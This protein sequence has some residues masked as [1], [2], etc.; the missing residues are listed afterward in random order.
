MSG[1]T[2]KESQPATRAAANIAANREVAN[3]IREVAKWLIL[4]FGAIGG[5]LLTG[6]QLSSIGKEGTDVF[7]AVVGFAVG[8]AGAGIALGFTVVV[9]LPTRIT[10]SGLA[11]NE[12]KGA[13]MRWKVGAL[14]GTLVAQDIGILDGHGE[15]IKDFET[16]RNSAINAVTAA[17][18]ELEAKEEEGAPIKPF[19][20]ALE[21]AE[22]K[23][24]KIGATSGELLSIAL[25]E[26]V[27]RRMIRA[28]AAVFVGGLM[29]AGG[30]GLFSW[31]TNQSEPDPPAAESVPMRPTGVTV[32]LTKRGQESLAAKLGPRCNTAKFRALA[33]GG[34]P[35][36]LEMVALRNSGC[37][38]VRF[39]LTPSVGHPQNELQV[40][41]RSATA[42]P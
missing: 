3:R 40:K 19:R 26:K 5:V 42:D 38:A 39:V 20:L 15:T 33:L 4:V 16:V 30:I 41:I 1:N 35:N 14:M 36:A 2:S 13:L 22:L 34:P 28:T 12:K 11:K 21:A 7:L 31:A 6:T 9:L 8:L 37:R 27:K 18:T 23:R 29:V 32:T 24:E 25:M 17:R 10:L